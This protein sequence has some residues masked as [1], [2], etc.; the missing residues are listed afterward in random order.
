LNLIRKQLR[1]LSNKVKITNDDILTTLQLQIL[2]REVTE[3]EEAAQAKKRLA[4][5]FRVNKS[6]KIK[7]EDKEVESAKESIPSIKS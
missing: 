2:K 6:S 4:A 1:A 3:G 7:K 5:A